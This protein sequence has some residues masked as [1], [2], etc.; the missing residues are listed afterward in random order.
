MIELMVMVSEQFS[1]VNAAP[2]ARRYLREEWCKVRERK[3]VTEGINASEG[4]FRKML[5]VCVSRAVKGFAP[6]KENLNDHFDYL[7]KLESSGKLMMSGPFFDAEPN[8]WSGDGLLIY[9]V[10]T[11]EE[12]SEIAANDPL[13]VSGSRSFEVRPWLWNDGTLQF[14]LR[15]SDQSIRVD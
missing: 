5:Y 4:R 15:F 8:S 9:N 7:A 6:I 1:Q 14:T 11:L 3:T 12:A 2:N 10:D 13:H